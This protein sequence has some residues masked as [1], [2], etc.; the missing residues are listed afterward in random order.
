MCGAREKDNSSICNM[1]RRVDTARPIWDADGIKSTRIQEEG[2]LLTASISLRSLPYGYSDSVSQQCYL[3]YSYAARIS[4]HRWCVKFGNEKIYYRRPRRL[5]SRVDGKMME[6]AASEIKKSRCCR[7]PCNKSV[8]TRP[9][10]LIR[11][12]DPHGARSHFQLM[13]SNVRPSFVG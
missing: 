12:L 6:K 8:K 7:V 10:L 4:L 5:K 11:G 1:I 9:G 13:S 2:I 3:P